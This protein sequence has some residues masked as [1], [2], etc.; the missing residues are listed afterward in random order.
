MPKSGATSSSSL[1][2][3]AVTSE[4]PGPGGADLLRDFARYA[5]ARRLVVGALLI[6]AGVLFEGL[7]ILLLVPL[8]DILLENGTGGGLAGGLAGTLISLFEGM[9][10]A[11]RMLVLLAAFAILIAA[12]ALVLVARDAH[13]A[14]LQHGFVANMR[15]QLISRLA[16]ASW[17]EVAKLKADRV[18]HALSS[19]ML[20]VATAAHY[21][22]QCGVAALMLAV[23]CL[24]AVLLA[25]KLS[26]IAMSLLLLVALVSGSFLKRSGQLGG[27]LLRQD[28]LMTDRSVGLMGVL[29]LAVAQ[30]LQSGFVEQYIRASGAA[31]SHRVGFVR[32]QSAARNLSMLLGALAGALTVLAGILL[33]QVHPTILIAF[34]VLL[35]RL[36][37]PATLVQQGAQQ[38]AHSLP[39]FRALRS[40]EAGLGPER[41]LPRRG[42]SG[43]NAHP[44]PCS[45][46]FNGVTFD[47]DGGLGEEGRG[48]GQVSV[49]LPAGSLIGIG[50]A[51]GSGKTTLVDLVAGIFQ[52]QE[53]EILID[54]IELCAATLDAHRDR[55]AYVGQD[56]VLFGDTVRRNLLWA[57]PGASDAEMW[58]AL[59]LVE[60]GELVRRLGDGLDSSLGA[61][62]HLLSTGE[63]QRIALARALLRRPSLLILDE[64]TSSIDAAGE[65]ILIERLCALAPRPTLLMISHRAESLALCERVLTFSA[66]KLVSDVDRPDAQ[67]SRIHIVAASAAGGG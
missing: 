65:R 3:H 5:G 8:L 64:A 52:P 25:P 43:R 19:D 7:G 16:L 22:L 46:A 12:R 63:R 59:D 13:V 42:A 17:R 32:L 58:E 45:I 34:L 54:G 53:G 40:L 24:F 35:S 4:R 1:P 23:Y 66:G 61:R 10:M 21:I 50:G 14:R 36:T 20:Q 26:V 48:V 2:G 51:S 33:L 6:G 67:T 9:S 38:I 62:G 18:V 15:S 56:A 57:A 29:K 44:L 39:A 37:A 49:F 27:A 30:N 55:L 31:V 41:N 11:A 28:L 47:H 60:A